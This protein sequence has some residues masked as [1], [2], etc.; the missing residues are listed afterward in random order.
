MHIY[1]LTNDGI[2]PRHFVEGKT[3]LK[4]SGLRDF[5]AMLAEGRIVRPSVTTIMSILA[6]PG[7]TSWKIDEYLKAAFE[8]EADTLDDFI[9]QS[10]M[11]AETKM[12]AAPSAGSD[13]HKLLSDY[14]TNRE[15]YKLDPDLPIAD[16]VFYEIENRYGFKP[17][18]FK[19][20]H[21]F[22]AG[23]Y[24]GQVDAH[25]SDLIL[26]FKTKQH[27]SKFKN[28]VQTDHI[29]QLAAYREGLGLPLA[30]CANVYVCLENGEVQIEQHDD[31]E[32][33]RCLQIFY[34]AVRL[35][36]LINKV[37]I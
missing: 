34:S 26:D 1:E 11:K 19:S 21:N 33:E 7:L 37:E 22:L 18:D 20:E 2:L 23:S 24:A 32:L 30:T 13:F 5:R 27:A 8:V 35:W 3:G 29:I 12:D 4:N 14:I 10:K 36:Y 15:G 17:D 16:R 31:S 28:L 25:N 9:L 6:K